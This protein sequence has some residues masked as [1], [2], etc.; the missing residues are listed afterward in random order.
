M[1]D[2]GPD[3]LRYVHDMQKKKKIFKKIPKPNKQKTPRSLSVV[4]VK[5]SKVGGVILSGVG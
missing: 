2:T 3:F 1:I 5:F 4:A